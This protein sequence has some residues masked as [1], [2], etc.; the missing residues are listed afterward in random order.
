M[1]KNNRYER[2]VSLDGVGEKGV[3]K[4]KSSKVLVVGAGGL[5]SPALLYLAAS[6]VGLIGIS[7]GDVVDISNL[8]RQIIHSEKDVGVEKI[9]SAK[10]KIESLNREVKVA[11]HP[12]VDEKNVDSVI[13]PYDFIIE[14]SDDI[15]TKFLINDACEN[16]KKAFSFG[17]ILRYYGQT[18]TVLSGTPTYRSVF[19]E[20][21]KDAIVENCSQ[22]GVLGVL[23]GV[24]GTIQAT[25]ALK[26]ILGIGE[27]LTGR[28]LTYDALKMRFK[29][30]DIKGD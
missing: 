6:G 30:L 4:I 7:D 25:E 13:E 1:D 12:P 15:K 14:A 18:M 29:I 16:Q 20:P 11:T 9:L 28:L 23:P 26:Y 10:K 24:I 21:P 27:L 3:L 22:A 19:K 17:G 5:G 8:Q 2:H